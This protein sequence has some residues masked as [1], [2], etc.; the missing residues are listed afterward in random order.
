MNTDAANRPMLFFNQAVVQAHLGNFNMA[1]ADLNEAIKLDPDVPRYYKL[2]SLAQLDILIDHMYIVLEGTVTVHTEQHG[3]KQIQQTLQPGSIFS[4][5]TISTNLWADTTLEAMTACRVL[6]LEHVVF[7]HTMKKVM[8]EGASARAAFFTS[9]GIFGE[10]SEEQR[11]TLGVLSENFNFNAGD[12]IVTEG[13]VAMHLYF[14]QSG[15]C[16]AVRLLGA[17]QTRIQVAML[18]SGDVF[19]EVLPVYSGI[20]FLDAGNLQAAV[21]DP[22]HG[23]FPFTIVANTICKIIRIEKN[24]LNKKNGF[25]LLRL[26]SVTKTILS[27]IQ[28]FSVRCP[29]DKLVCDHP[30]FSLSGMTV[31]RQLVQMIRDSCSWK[32]ERKKVLSAFAK[33]MSKASGKLPRVQSEPQL[34]KYEL[35]NS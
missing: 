19:G 12:V 31:A 2:R 20:T 27:K 14:V 23:S 4:E 30:P 6:M 7:K 5:A 21:L 34:S 15:L 13:A 8:M 3:V 29:Q 18:S 22:I 25:E 17:E 33:D 28:Q 26:G 9:T 11:N 10:W 16:G 32:L 35:P 24:Y 1:M